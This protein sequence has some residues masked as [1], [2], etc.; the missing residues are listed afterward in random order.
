VSARLRLLR[1]GACRGSGFSLP[2]FLLPSSFFPLF[3]PALEAAW[4]TTAERFPVLGFP[5]RDS[6]QI[7]IFQDRGRMGHPFGCRGRKTPFSSFQG[8]STRFLFGLSKY[9]LCFRWLL[10]S[11]PLLAASP[12]LGQGYLPWISVGRINGG[13]PLFFSDLPKSFC[14]FLLSSALFP[15]LAGATFFLFDLFY[16]GFLAFFLPRHLSGLRWSLTLSA[17]IHPC[18]RILIF[19]VPTGAHPRTQN[20]LS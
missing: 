18:P 5:L 2:E 13:A 10:S 4:R 14:T 9:R 8:S 16:G 11:P 17:S 19:K 20:L 15:K 1:Q 3:T 7:L 6:H 12:T